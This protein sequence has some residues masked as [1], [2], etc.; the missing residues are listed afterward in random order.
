MTKLL[1]SAVA[2]ALIAGCKKAPPETP[3]PEP[4]PAKEAPAA[5][6]PILAPVHFETGSNTVVGTEM[7]V[8]DEAVE[9]LKST[10]WDLI[11]VGLSD[12]S[13]DDETNK[14]LSQQR[15]EAVAELVRTKAGVAANRISAHGIGERLATA[16]TVNERKVEFV[17]YHDT[18]L[19][20]RQVVMQSG[21]L[22]EDVRTKRSE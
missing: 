19:T 14:V 3:A 12:A 11:V 2:L 21:V 1:V 6:A 18:G 5:K 15:A 16:T 17:F 8:V 22:A 7:P 20:P 13:G 10:N 9:I 4:E